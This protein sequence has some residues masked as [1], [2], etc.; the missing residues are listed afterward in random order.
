[1]SHET[2][3]WATADAAIQTAIQIEEIGRDFYDAFGAATSDPHMAELCRK[4][5]IDESDHER[6]FRRI[7]SKLAAEGG[8]VLLR[9][10]QL[11][12]ARQ[13]AKGAILPNRDEILRMVHEGHVADLLE[14]AIKMERDSIRFYQAIAANL[15]DAN[16]VEDVVRQEQEHLRLVSAAKAGK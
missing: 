8:T 5:A 3:V 11:A 7:R 12:E 13:V 10:D 4:L 1:M 16:A 15:P 6:D 2:A 9:D 14:M